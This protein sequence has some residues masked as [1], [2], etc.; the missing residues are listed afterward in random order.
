VATRP[1]LPEQAVDVRPDRGTARHVSRPQRLAV[2]GRA[3]AAVAAG[4]LIAG[5]FAPV[6]AWPL[7]ILGVALFTL[8]CR[9]RSAR[10]GFG[11]GLLAGLGI[12]VPVLV[13]SAS[14]GS[15]PGL[16]SRR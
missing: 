14:S 10:G 3:L 9:R 6:D 15:M 11:Y 12:F 13:C 5:T 8:V 1:A 2:G 4:A 7:S 16:P